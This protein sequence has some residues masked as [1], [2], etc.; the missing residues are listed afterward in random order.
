MHNP[1]NDRSMLPDVVDEAALVNGVRREE[2]F[3]GFFVFVTKLA[4]GLGA[5]VS[6]I[7]YKCVEMIS[8]A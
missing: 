8:Y 6:L 1:P 2:L 4:M 7:F 3:Y 5:G